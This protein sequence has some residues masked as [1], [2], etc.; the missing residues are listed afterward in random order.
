[1]C[2][3]ECPANAIVFRS[4]PTDY[5]AT[6][7]AAVLAAKGG[8]ASHK[9]VAYVCGHH[10]SAAD[11]LGQ[12]SDVPGVEEIY[13]PSVAGIG[14]LDILK[15][16][17]NGA[18]SVLVIACHEGTDRYPKANQRLRARVDQARELL[19]EAGMDGKKLQMLELA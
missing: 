16:F 10:A 17:E 7:T 15:A 2:V 18:D 12:T 4:R 3:A 6:R 1:M 11:W 19:R 9:V 13:V 14:A 8:A 5:L